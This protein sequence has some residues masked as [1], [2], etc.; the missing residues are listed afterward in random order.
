MSD[1]LAPLCTTS[2]DGNEVTLSLPHIRLGGRLWGEA[3]KPLLLALHGWLDNANSFAPLAQHL[4][5]YR[6]LAI[7]WPG[8]GASQHRPGGYPLHWIDYL[9]DLELL[10]DTI[11][12]HQ[13]L[14]GVIG[15]SLGGI[16][17]SA[18]SAAFAEKAEHWIFIEALAPLFEAP[19][20]SK[21]RLRRSF[22][23]HQR[24]AMSQ[25]APKPVVLDAAV[26][27]RHK[28]TGL[29]VPWCRLI[30]ERNLQ[31]MNG[32]FF[33]RSDPRLKLDSPMR[34][35]FDH[36]SGLMQDHAGKVL[37]IR[38]KDGYPL[39]GNVSETQDGAGDDMSETVASWYQDLTLVTLEGDH[40]LHMGNSLEVAGAIKAFLG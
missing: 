13:P 2:P 20:K 10:I 24:A 5:E 26:R 7:D 16:V 33:W 40:H 4:S 30:L 8:H 27:A 19:T 35:N 25:L 31:F 38:A 34:L 18:Y 15:H 14:H 39:M 17:A 6:L 1:P 29:D 36:V 3:D 22:D 28:L 37:A 32:H 21:L 9:Y 23:T 12:R 11:V